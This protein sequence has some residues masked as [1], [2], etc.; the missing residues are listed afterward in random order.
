M[1]RK[2][3]DL[4]KEYK[5]KLPADLGLIIEDIK[6][7]GRSDLN[8]LMTLRHKYQAALK[9]LKR[10]DDKEDKPVVELDPEAQIEKELD[11]AISRIEKDKKRAA[12]KER[13][14]K[15]KSDLRQKM[16]VIATSTGIDND[17]ELNMNT[18]LWDELR[19]KGFEHL[20]EESEAEVSE[21]EDS[22]SDENEEEESPEED[23]DVDEKQ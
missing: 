13:E 8:K 10:G 7:C 4:L 22:D 6:V 14:L 2:A 19:E 12:K 11:Q 18:R 23:L 15:A 9:L 16:S 17:E 3:E 20:D 21:E 1:D 5:V